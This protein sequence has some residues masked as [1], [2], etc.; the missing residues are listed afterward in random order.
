MQHLSCAQRKFS[1]GINGVAV[2]HESLRAN[3]AAYNTR[4]DLAEGE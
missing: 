2:T 4:E 1:S 3:S